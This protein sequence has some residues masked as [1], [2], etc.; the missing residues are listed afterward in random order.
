MYYMDLEERHRCSE[1]SAE[2]SPAF[3]HLDHEYLKDIGYLMINVSPSVTRLPHGVKVVVVQG[4]KD[5][6]WPRPRGYAKNGKVEDGSLEALVRTGTPGLCY[7]YYTADVNS[8]WGYRKG[9]KHTAA[10]LLEHR[11]HVDCVRI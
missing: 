5:E 2:T 9:D 11:S 10:S 8:N 6:K 7:L 1:S 4:A 3:Q